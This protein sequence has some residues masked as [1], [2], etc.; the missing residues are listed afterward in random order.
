MPFLT[1]TRLY[2]ATFIHHATYHATFIHHATYHATVIHHATYHATFIHHTTRGVILPTIPN[3][4]AP[5]KL[6]TY[7]GLHNLNKD[8]Q[9]SHFQTTP[10]SSPQQT[11]TTTTKHKD[12]HQLSPIYLPNNNRNYKIYTL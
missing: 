10:D 9:Y 4:I 3:L 11:P 5:P 8:S 1:V 12:M 6:P 7:F 2:L